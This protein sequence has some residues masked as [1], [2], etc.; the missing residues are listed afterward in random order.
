MN[1]QI[2]VTFDVPSNGQNYPIRARTQTRHLLEISEDLDAHRGTYT[3]LPLPKNIQTS[4]FDENGLYLN[5]ESCAVT[6]NLGTWYMVSG[7]ISTQSFNAPSKF[8]FTLNSATTYLAT[9]SEDLC[10]QAA[11]STQNIVSVTPT[12]LTRDIDL[13]EIDNQTGTSALV[14]EK[15]YPVVLVNDTI[16]TSTGVVTFDISNYNGL[17][18]LVS[19]DANKENFSIRPSTETGKKEITYKVCLVDHPDICSESNIF[20]TLVEKRPAISATPDISTI[21]NTQTGTIDILKNDS[22]SGAIP[23]PNDVTLTLT[24]NTTDIPGIHI[25]DNGKI[26]V[27]PVS[28]E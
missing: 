13:G 24:G 11:I 10:D 16:V 28:K 5:A 8:N 25:D 15:I 14:N 18:P 9:Y 12:I 26:I 19:L 27:P 1:N 6:R 7:D 20:F 4:D 2:R 17:E 21:T 23:T 3:P 22:F